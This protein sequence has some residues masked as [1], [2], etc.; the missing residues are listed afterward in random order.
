MKKRAA[1]KEA[2][3]NR[4]CD[5]AWSGLYLM[6]LL[7]NLELKENNLTALFGRHLINTS[8]TTTER[9]NGTD[10]VEYEA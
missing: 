3:A 9:P 2:K 5:P 6:Y 8:L 1:S 4:G 10:T 7:T